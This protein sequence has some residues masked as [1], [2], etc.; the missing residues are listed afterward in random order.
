MNHTRRFIDEWSVPHKGEQR[1]WAQTFCS[2]T[3]R[4]EYWFYLLPATKSLMGQSRRFD[5]EPATSGL[6]R[7]TDIVRP[8]RLVRLVPQ[9][10]VDLDYCLIWRTT[11]V[12]RASKASG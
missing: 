2:Q 8:A 10:E 12:A 7:S 4:R 3:S 9:A 11:C 1:R 6:P 5:P